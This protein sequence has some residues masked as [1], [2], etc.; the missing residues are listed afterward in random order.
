MHTFLKVS[1]V[2]DILRVNKTTVQRWCA[3]GKLP[4]A[5]IGKHW[6][7][8]TSLLKEAL[9][10]LSLDLSAESELAALVSTLEEHP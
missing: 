9:G 6:R 10:A 4:A 7:I 5:K 8:N 2:A 1:E 3:A